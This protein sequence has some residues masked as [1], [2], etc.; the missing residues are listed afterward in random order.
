M[1]GRIRLGL[2]GTGWI[3]GL[4][5]R[6]LERLDRTELVGTVSRST[7]RAA[8]IASRWGGQPYDDVVELLQRE[9]PDAVIVCLPPNRSPA[10]CDVLIEHG[11]P[12][13]TE[14]PLAAVADDAERV[15]ARLWSGTPMAAV[16]YQWR[17]LDFLPLVRERLAARP[18]RLVLG[19][20]TGGLPAPRWW[21]HVAESG[22]QIVEQATHLYDLA[23]NLVGEAEVVAAASGRWPRPSV[24]DADVDD[25]G[26]AIVR[27]G[28]GSV[29][30]F[31]NASLL[32][33]AVVELDLIADGRRTTI[34]MHPGEPGPSWTLTLDDG[35]GEQTIGTRRD[36]YEIQAERFLDCL[37]SGDPGGLLSSYADALLTD[38]LVRAVVTE[39]RR[40]DR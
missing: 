31:I 15:A 23:R 38:R 5:L 37:A 9:R 29:G 10:A 27:F 22:G 33:S 16:G 20:W 11:I 3:T 24:P 30:S 18:V 28:D 39:S 40:R 35:D 7:E 12:F 1:T 6:A 2:V 32:E 13:L 36:P 19:R 25:V 8:A 26:A 17:A 4:H 21:R 14:K 34:R